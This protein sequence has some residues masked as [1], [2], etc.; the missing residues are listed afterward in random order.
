MAKN[1]PSSDD[2]G[3]DATTTTE[4]PMPPWSRDDNAI[5]VGNGTAVDG[6]GDDDENR[7]IGGFPLQNGQ[8]PFLI[9]LNVGY[10]QF[11]TTLI[12]VDHNAFSPFSCTGTILSPI[13]VLTAAHCLYDQ[14]DN[15]LSWRSVSVCAGLAVTGDCSAAGGQ[16][17]AV[18]PNGLFEHD[19]KLSTTR[20]DNLSSTFF[21]PR[22]HSWTSGQ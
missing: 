8:L 6:Q 1:I 13:W 11:K 2:G 18:A 21:S 9:R 16:G 14:N 19:G 7:I 22:L 3:D 17:R 12:I 5:H 20:A 4:L 15:F 10:G